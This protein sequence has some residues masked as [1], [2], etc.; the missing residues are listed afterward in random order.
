MNKTAALLATTGII[1]TATGQLSATYAGVKQKAWL[2]SN[3][4]TAHENPNCKAPGGDP[5]A[6]AQGDNGVT[7]N[8]EVISPRDRQSG[9]PEGKRAADP[10]GAPDQSKKHVSN[11][12]WSPKAG[13]TDGGSTDGNGAAQEHAINSKGSGTAG[14]VDT[15]ND[16]HGAAARTRSL[17]D[18]DTLDRAP[19]K[20][21]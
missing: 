12:K 15:G 21:Q 2:C 10:T 5:H 4:K 14:R 1:F 13:G 19:A 17:K 11:I 20:P 3:F 16:S 7:Q 8:H 9:L 6:K 18:H